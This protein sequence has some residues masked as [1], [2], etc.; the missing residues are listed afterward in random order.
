MNTSDNA[1]VDKIEGIS[2]LA[3][4]IWKARKAYLFLTPLFAGLIIFC[5]YPPLSG[6]LRSFYN[7][8]GVGNSTFIGMANF[9]ELFKDSVFLNSIGTMLILL[10]PRLII[11]I[12][13]PFIMAELIFSVKTPKLQS[14]YRVGILMPIVAP[15]I[16]FLLIWKYVYDPNIGLVTTLLKAL[17]LI[18][19]DAVVNY[20]N[21]VH[22]V[23]PAIIFMGFPW[24][25]GTSVLIYMSGLMNVSGEMLEASRLDGAGVLKRIYHIDIPLLMGQFRY[26]I[27]F[28]IIGGL[29]DYGIQIV[30]TQGGPGY[31]TYVPGYYMYTEAFVA[32]R[33]GYACAIGTTI[34]IVIFILSLSVFKYLKTGNEAIDS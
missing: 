25:G 24:I 30:L 32:G 28:G 20:L 7:W 16:V 10:I 23:I 17:Q 14:A 11:G 27:I 5:Y 2:G 18:P 26:F 4:Q 6:I 12:T 21:D 19:N 33:M 3:G 29:Q 8:D 13:V 34:F 31:S 9:V 15:G 1:S 22:L